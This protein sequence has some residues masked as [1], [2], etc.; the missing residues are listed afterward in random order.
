MQEIKKKKSNSGKETVKAGF[1]KIMQLGAAAQKPEL[2]PREEEGH[3]ED[4]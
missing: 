4:N 2:K 3:K 1:N